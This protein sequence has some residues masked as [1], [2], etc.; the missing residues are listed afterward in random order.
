MA[1]LTDSPAQAGIRPF[2]SPFPS[3]V[4]TLAAAVAAVP[5]RDALVCGPHR[6]SYAAFGSA[7][8]GF[9]TVLRDA[10]AEG[11]VVLVCLRNSV[12][13]AVALYAAQAAGAAVCPANPDYTERELRPV[14]EDAAPRVIVTKAE[15]RAKLEAALSEGS[16]TRIMELPED[17]AG[18]LATMPEGP[19]LADML[20][21]PDSVAALLYT[22]GTTGLP[23]GVMH[24][25]RQVAANVAQ[26]EHLLP[27]LDGDRVLCMMPLFHTFALSTCLHLSAWCRGTL[28]VLPR[29]RP[30]W[31]VDTIAAERITLMPAGPT[32]FNGLLSFDGLDRTKLATLRACYSG[33]APL[34]VDTLER[35]RAATGCEIYEGY[36]QTEAGPIVS[37]NSPHFPLR[38]GSVGKPLPD[39]V[40]QIVDVDTG[41]TVLPRGQSG[42]IRVRGPQVMLGYRNKPE[43][44]AEALREG[45]LHTGDIGRFDD[46]GYLFIQ[47]RKKDIV[48]TGGFNVYPREIDEVLTGHPAVEEA[49]TIGVPDSY[50]GEV[51]WAYVRLAAGAAIG[52]DDL[53]SHCAANLVKYKLPQRIVIVDALPK[54]A[55]NKIDK[56]ALRDRAKAG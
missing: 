53:L 37:F 26:R 23:K 33:S 38:T 1:T 30:D 13:L 4:H 3:V 14:L 31:V 19:D 48:I 10:G 17:T 49:A 9:A 51:L 45:W 21:D 5:E 36:G 18:W 24:A 15:Q 39:T 22:G 7:V 54:T 29:Y 55:V 27:T 2:P 56:K 6:L 28:V 8:A 12:E 50:R 16:G 52:Q 32:V 25:H 41:T 43:A 40:V 46:E 20:P 34:S 35:W 42:E 47:D 11:G 44:T